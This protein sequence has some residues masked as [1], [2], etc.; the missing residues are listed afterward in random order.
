M[1]LLRRGQDGVRLAWML[2][3]IWPLAVLCGMGWGGAWWVYGVPRA[4]AAQ[5]LAE[6][7]AGYTAAKEARIQLDRRRILAKQVTQAQQE[8]A[9][10]WR[11]LPMEQEFSS[12]ALAVSE[13]GR[14]EGVT[15]PGMTYALKPR[16]G[17]Q[18]A[19]EA[20]LSFQATGPYRGIYQ[21]VRK[22]ERSESYVVIE[23]LNVRR[24]SSER[25]GQAGSVQ[26][27]V[28]LTTF[29]KPAALKAGTS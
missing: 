28:T 9:L 24:D 17:G 3:A 29:L 16:K 20:T 27:D 10:V 12:L 13:L 1:K 23:R 19:V 26:F 6:A 14:A 8:L 21:F 5:A 22:L 4:Q 25:S 15:I 11:T 2:R 7:E 18:V